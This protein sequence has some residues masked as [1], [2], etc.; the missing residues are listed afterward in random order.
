MR[1]IYQKF[2]FKMFKS[3]KYVAAIALIVNLLACK[4]EPT[5]VNAEPATATNNSEQITTGS[6]GNISL[7]SKEKIVLKDSTEY[8]F[9]KADDK[10]SIVFYFATPGQSQAGKTAL[11][12]EGLAQ[13]NRLT[14]TL[15]GAG[16]TMIFADGNAAMQTT[17]GVSKANQGDLNVFKAEDAAETLKF[18]AAN[19]MGKKVM[20][21]AAAPIISE[22]M[23]Q[24]TGKP[25]PTVPSTDNSNLYV[26]T[27]KS[28]GDGEAKVMTY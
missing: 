19:Y 20:V 13:A 28:M 22:M 7:I 5:G 10:T 14:A 18:L 3:T 23:A 12:E 16:L 15:A 2:N 9:P 8:I 26:V 21:C 6:S 17:L 11:S 24:L 4:N 27:S 25:A 1:P